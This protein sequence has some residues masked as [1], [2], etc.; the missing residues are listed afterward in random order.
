M[1]D[2][3]LS[4]GLV[5]TVGKGDKERII[6]LGDYA[7]QWLE[8]YLD[9]ARPLLVK[10]A[11]EIMYLSIIMGKVFLGKESGKSEAVSTRGWDLQSNTTYAAA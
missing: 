6:P 5:Q 3:H 4:L 1:G 10:D 8:R 2:L 7:I 11:S 9:E